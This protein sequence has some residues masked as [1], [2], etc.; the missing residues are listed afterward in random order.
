M[1]ADERRKEIVAV[2]LAGKSPISGTA[3]AEQLSVSRQIIVQ[4]IAVLKASGYDILA[5][6]NGYILQKSPLV[7]RIFKV[8]HTTNETED[9]LTSIVSHG[10]TVVDV[11]VWHKVYGRIEAKLNIFSEM[12]VSSAFT[13]KAGAILCHRAARMTSYILLFRFL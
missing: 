12:H 13:P 8:Y 7:E 10:G 11:Y 1:K 5:T 9:E 3:L 4:D 2:L 6:H